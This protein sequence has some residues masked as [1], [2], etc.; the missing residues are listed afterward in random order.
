MFYKSKLTRLF[1]VEVHVQN[2]HWLQYVK[3]VEISLLIN[4][5]VWTSGQWE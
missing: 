2:A 5:L 3:F 1:K 4:V